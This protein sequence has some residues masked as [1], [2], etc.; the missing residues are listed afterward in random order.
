SDTDP[1][2]LG[3]FNGASIC[4]QTPLQFDRSSGRSQSWSFEA[5]VNTDLDG[6]VNFL[7]GAIYANVDSTDGDYYVNAFPIDY[8]AGL[9]GSFTSFGGGLPPSFLGTPFFRNSTQDFGLESYG[10]FG[11]IYWDI[12]DDLTFTGGLRYNIDEKFT[13]A[14]ST[15]ASFLVPYGTATDAFDSPFVGTFDADPGRAGNQLIQRRQANFAEI[16]GR[17]VL[18]WQ[19]TPDNSIYISYSRGYKSGGINPPLQ[20]IFAVPETFQPESIDA[21]EIGSRNVFFNGDLT[22]NATAFYYKYS[23]L[24][25]S[26]IVA[27]TSVNDNIDADIWGLELEA[28]WRPTD[29]LAFNFGASYLNTEVS[30]DRFFVNQRDPSGGDPNSVIIKD[31]TAAFNCAATS[32]SLANTAGFVT[33]VNGGLGLQGPATFPADSGLGTTL[34]AFS[35][36]NVL[37]AQT[38]NPALQ[39][40]FP[41]VTVANSGIPFNIRGNELPQ[42]PDFKVSFGAQYTAEFNNGMTFVPRVDAAYT[43]DSFGNIFNGDVNRVDGYWQ[44][45]AQ[46]TLNGP[47]ERWFVRAFV[48]NLFNDDSVTGLYLTDQSSGLFTNIFTLEPRRYGIAAGVRF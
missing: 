44:V 42:A 35:I 38:A 30:E 15:L 20:P 3:S 36:C 23:G 5:I 18:D 41:G 24:Q 34:G 13:V 29:A 32:G 33:A 45:N 11:E 12:T 40:L 14:R 6:P 22:L 7:L 2:G 31:I 27:R 25:L 28:F 47:D 26:R 39:A 43:G 10:A 17:A 1:N 19:F 48:Q 4:S 9:L 8:I 37:Q 46:M 21:F 16:T